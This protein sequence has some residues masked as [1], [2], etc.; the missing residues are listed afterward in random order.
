MHKIHRFDAVNVTR[1]VPLLHAFLVERVQAFQR[2]CGLPVAGQWLEAH[3]TIYR[4][5]RHNHNPFNCDKPILGPKHFTDGRVTHHTDMIG[6]C[7][8]LK[9]HTMKT[10]AV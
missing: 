4:W 2:Y 8:Y 10:I 5:G 6:Y 1:C 3:S 9:N 7:N